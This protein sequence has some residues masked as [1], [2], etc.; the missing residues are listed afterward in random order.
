M[1]ENSVIIEMPEVGGESN[2]GFV[3][4]EEN[5]RSNTRSQRRSFQQQRQQQLIQQQRITKI[6]WSNFCQEHCIEYCYNSNT[7]ED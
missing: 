3:D 4:E 2:P 6:A 7:K 1:D 5:V